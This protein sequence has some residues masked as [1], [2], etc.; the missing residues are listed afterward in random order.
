MKRLIRS[1]IF[2]PGALALLCIGILTVCLLWGS[3]EGAKFVPDP[4]PPV[5]TISEWVEPIPPAPSDQSAPAVPDSAEPS[6]AVPEPQVQNVQEVGD[7]VIINFT[8]PV[9]PKGTPPPPPEVTVVQGDPSHPPEPSPAPTPDSTEDS[10]ETPKSDTP[11][12]GSR[13]DKGEVYD[14]VF[15]WFVPGEVISEPIDNDGDPNKMVGHMN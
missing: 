12:P 11:A 4:A 7:N 1:K 3:G 6:A 14:P 9:Q 5:E 13:N 10:P 15:G 2:V 8:D